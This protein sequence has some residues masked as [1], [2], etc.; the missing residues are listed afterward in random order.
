METGKSTSDIKLP[1]LKLRVTVKRSS[2]EIE[3]KIEKKENREKKKEGV[4]NPSSDEK[5]V[6]TSS[7]T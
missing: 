5:N 6:S 3:K 2:G 7:N 4:N 1:D